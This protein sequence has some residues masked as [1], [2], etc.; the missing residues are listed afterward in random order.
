MN[1]DKHGHMTDILSILYSHWQNTP[2]HCDTWFRAHSL[3][4]CPILV[5]T[6]HRDRRIF[7]RC[8]SGLLRLMQ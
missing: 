6:A 5:H 8:W 2:M 4:S 1:Q 3:W 7:Y